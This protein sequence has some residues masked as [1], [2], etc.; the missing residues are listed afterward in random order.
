MARVTDSQHIINLALAL[1]S[2]TSL[3]D[4][5]KEFPIRQAFE[6]LKLIADKH[7]KASPDM[8]RFAQD[9]V[10]C[11]SAMYRLPEDGQYTVTEF[12]TA[13]IYVNS[14]SRTKKEQWT[15]KNMPSKAAVQLAK[16][17]VLMFKSDKTP[18]SWM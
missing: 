3:A 6:M 1:T 16:S 11:E 10:K 14:L 12:I 13:M 15:L 5:M 9:V 8:I 7:I 17:L 2:T 18:F 4:Y